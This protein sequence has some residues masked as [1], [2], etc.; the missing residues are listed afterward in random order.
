MEIVQLSPTTRLNSVLPWEGN[1]LMK[2]VLSHV[3]F[4]MD[5]LTEK[6]RRDLIGQF[7]DNRKKDGKGY[8]AKH[9]QA[10]VLAQSS[11]YRVLARID[12][13]ETAERRPG[14]G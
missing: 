3:W 8:V 12:K 4:V 6:Q 7:Y 5:G 9:F 2:W 13:E 1:Q 10:L 11:V 14:S